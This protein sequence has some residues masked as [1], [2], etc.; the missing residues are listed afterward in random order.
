MIISH[1]YKFIFIKTRKTAGTSIEISLSKFCDDADV[2]SELGEKE[3][4]KEQFG[5]TGARNFKVPMSQ[6]TA[7]DFVKLPLRGAPV[8]YSHSPAAYVRARVPAEI[9]RDYYT[10]AFER[11]PYDRIVSQYFWNTRETGQPVHDYLDNAASYRLSNWEVYTDGKEIIVDHVAQFANL[12]DELDAF[13]EKVG[14]P[15]PIELARA[16]T[17]YRPK[18]KSNDILDDRVRAKIAKTCANE[19]ATFGYAAPAPAAA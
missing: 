4:I 10:I 15:E 2:V 17:E 11:N 12:K 1:K 13:A 6:W 16:K 3:E 18:A 19:I 9:W 7:R 8:F 14:L 5:Y